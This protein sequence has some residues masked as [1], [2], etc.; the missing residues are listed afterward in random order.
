MGRNGQLRTLCALRNLR[1]LFLVSRA[2][3]PSCP[4]CSGRT[5]PLTCTSAL[6]VASG[7]VGVSWP[8][9]KAT[10]LYYGY[11]Y[12]TDTYSWAILFKKKI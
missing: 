3:F 8:S 4:L 1:F 11:Y 9:R 5:G 6:S 10:A 7:L 2:P 12:H